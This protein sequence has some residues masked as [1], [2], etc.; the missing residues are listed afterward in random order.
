MIVTVHPE[1]Y[2]R[3][4]TSDINLS[5]NINSNN[6]PNNPNNPNDPMIITNAFKY[7][8]YGTIRLISNLLSKYEL[9]KTIENKTNITEKMFEHLLANP[10]ILIYQPEFR[11]LIINKINEIEHIINTHKM[12]FKIAKYDE[13]FNI[14]KQSVNAHI[15]HSSIITSINSKLD[16]IV[17]MINSYDKFISRKNLLSTINSMKLLLDDIKN[18]PNYIQ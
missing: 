1:S 13:A 8:Y 15:Q 12:A 2:H 6:N 17:D 5:T 7:N 14:V 9:D 10:N 16:Q 3:I 11:S 18:S 4:N